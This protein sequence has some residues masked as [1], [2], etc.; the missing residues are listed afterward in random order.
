MKA[1]VITSGAIFALL[2]LAHIVR[3]VVEGPHVLSDVFFVSATLIAGG[4]A[5]WAWRVTRQM[6]PL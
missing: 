2:V 5:A 3:V 6:A 1:Y 4:L